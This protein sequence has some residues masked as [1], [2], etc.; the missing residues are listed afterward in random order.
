MTECKTAHYTTSTPLILGAIIARADERELE[1]LKK[2]GLKLGYAFQI[3]DDILN[4]EGEEVQYGKETGGDIFEGKRTLILIHLL[5]H[6]EEK[7]KILEIMNKPREKKTREEVI[8]VIEL[9]K[10][11]GSINYAREKAI[12]FA[13]EARE[14]LERELAG[15]PNKEA[16]EKLKKITDFVATRAK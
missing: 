3:Q 7:D 1:I 2:I 11:Y 14:I 16:F 9:A 4:L 13:R 12:N 6:A 10:K 8:W 5:K 15:A